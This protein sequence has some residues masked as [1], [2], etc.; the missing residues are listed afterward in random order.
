MLQRSVGFVNILL[1]ALVA[2][3]VFGIWL[4]YNPVN[5]SFG[6]YLE[7]QQEVIRALNVIMPILGAIGILFTI[8]STTLARAEKKILYILI[9]AILCLIIAGLVTRFGNQPINA[10]VMT[11]N[12]QTLPSNWTELRDEWW[13]YH[14]FR[15]LASVAGLC[16]ILIANPMQQRK[17]KSLS[18]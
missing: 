15:T 5:L 10:I 1:V 6:A 14:I 18:N 13:M 11:W 9:G 4:G 7:Q 12:L 2:G 3:S 8:V 17:N 16:L